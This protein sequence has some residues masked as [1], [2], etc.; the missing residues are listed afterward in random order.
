M[1]GPRRAAIVE[2]V[3]SVLH[4][5]LWVDANAGWEGPTALYTSLTSTKLSMGVGPCAQIP[6]RDQFFAAWSNLRHIM[7]DLRMEG[8]VIAGYLSADGRFQ[9]RHCLFVVRHSLFAL[10]A[11]SLTRWC[12]E[13]IARRRHQLWYVYC[14]HHVF[15]FSDVFSASRCRYQGCVALSRGGLQQ[16]FSCFQSN[17]C[18][19][20]S[21]CLRSKWCIGPPVHV[22]GPST[23]LHRQ[24]S[25][26]HLPL[27][28]SVSW[29]TY[30]GL[31]CC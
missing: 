26:I 8:A 10:R 7:D 22:Q 30:R 19:T 29:S 2:V 3:G 9:I 14:L 1:P 11:S 27:S 15:S 18:R 23:R 31:L 25:I 28:N 4:D 20:P 21:P 6:L 16:R 24:V 17:A 12:T 5:R 13:T